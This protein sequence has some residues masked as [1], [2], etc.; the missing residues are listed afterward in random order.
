MNQSICVTE[1]MELSKWRGLIESRL[2]K[3]LGKI[4]EENLTRDRVLAECR[5]AVDEVLGSRYAS[6]GKVL[7]TVYP[8]MSLTASKKFQ[9]GTEPP[10]V[11]VR[12]SKRSGPYQR[13]WVKPKNPGTPSQQAHR[14]RFR[15][16][17]LAW[18]SESRATKQYWE[19]LVRR[20]KGMTTQGLYV[21][22]WF[23]NHPSVISTG[24]T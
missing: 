19:G 16:A 18:K 5:S 11:Y 13:Q 3:R 12:K 1:K 21:R 2:Q 23:K 14:E 17:M 10:V 24:K 8:L 4:P 22:N 9:R 6:G 20:M 15:Q 7:L